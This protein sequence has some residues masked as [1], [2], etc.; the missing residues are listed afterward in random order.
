MKMKSLFQGFIDD[1]VRSGRKSSTVYNHRIMIDKFIGPAIGSMTL[2]EIR[3]IHANILADF[4]RSS[5]PS[6]PS[7]AV[8]TMR[9][10]LS[11]AVACG[12]TLAFD[13]RDIEVPR[14]RTKNDVQALTIDEVN[15]IRRALKDDVLIG[16]HV[17]KE[18]QQA[19]AYVV[20]RTLCL[21]EVLLHTG[22][23]ISE[24]LAIDIA[25]LDLEKQE[26]RVQNVKTEEW[27]T[28]Y[29]YGCTDAINEYLKFR[30]DENPALFI[31]N[32]GVRLPI[33][34]AKSTLARLK[35]RLNLKKPLTHK[36]F[37]ATF[38]TLLLRA[39]RDPKE[40]QVLARHKSLQ[41]T[42]DY[43]YKVVKEELKVV[44]E[45]VMSKI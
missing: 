33:E 6:R 34:T 11:Y 4:A 15:Y 19:H 36:I 3:P 32:T 35:K 43:Y 41:T 27:D 5:G 37:R 24:A 38:V 2:S 21:F 28:V 9:R 14:Y 22:L 20:T 30:Q 7:Q 29:L 42:L 16:K 26:L 1:C 10:I 25:D 8:I 13:W 23:R 12:Y 40:V 18:L 31:S 39:K 44:H 45:A 17:S